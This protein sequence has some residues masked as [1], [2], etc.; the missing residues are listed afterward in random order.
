[1]LGI[2]TMFGSFFFIAQYLQL[3]LGLTPLRAGL[4]MLPSS[5]AFIAAS[6]LSPLVTRRARPGH[7]MAGGLAVS[8]LGFTVIA[9]MSASY[10]L[11]AIV[12]GAIL[13][14]LGASPVVTLATDLVVG[15]APAERA[16]AASAIS[17]TSFELGGALGIAVLGSIASAVYRRDMG[18]AVPRELPAAAAEVAAETLGGAVMVAAQLSGDAGRTLLLAARDAFVQ[19]FELTAAISAFIG[20]LAAGM[21]AVLLRRVARA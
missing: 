8:A 9:G 12:A 7:V 13:I 16:G 15:A 11:P 1:M 6:L 10:G 5:L 21:A 4:W 14:S 20:M 18:D 19:S 2:F 17:E 3:V